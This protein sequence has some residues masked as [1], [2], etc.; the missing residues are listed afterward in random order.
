MMTQQ[1]E[2]NLDYQFSLNSNWYEKIATAVGK[3][4]MADQVLWF[5]RKIGIGG[6]K[7]FEVTPEVSVLVFDAVLNQNTCFSRSPNLD[8]DDFWILCF[9]LQSNEYHISDNRINADN[10]IKSN[11][12]ILD[13][14]TS[15]AYFVKKGCRGFS[16]RILIKKDYLDR[17]FNEKALTNHIHQ[18]FQI[19]RF[20]SKAMDSRSKVI[21]NNLSKHELSSLNY[22]FLLKGV[23]YNLLGLFSEK[24]RCN[25]LGEGII[26]D[27]DREAIVRSNEYLCS[28]LTLPFPGIAELVK[29]ANMSQ[30]KYRVLYRSIMGTTPLLYFRQQKLLLGKKMLESGDFNWVGDVAFE[31]GYN[32]VAYFSQIYKNQFKVNPFESLRRSNLVNK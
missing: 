29:I 19:Q 4:I 2:L 30:T 7:F 26:Y 10:G 24:Q 9:D 20:F 12:T 16:V 22:N 25:T 15:S 31:L 17:Y 28:R 21:L 8:H 32:K 1:T 3:K 27:R 11:V 13:N 18:D 14:K 6:S 5:P 23:V